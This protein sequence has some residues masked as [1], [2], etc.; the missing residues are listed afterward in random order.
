[1]PT[2]TVI[3]GPEE[4][5]HTVRADALDVSGGGLVFTSSGIVT[6]AYAPHGYTWT[7][8]EEE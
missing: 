1:M 7:R 2:W 5:E 6:R 4:R 3:V 8:L